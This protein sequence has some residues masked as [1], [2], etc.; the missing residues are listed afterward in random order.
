MAATARDHIAWLETLG[1]ADVPSVGG[2][3][4]SLGEMIRHLAS[5]GVRVPGGFATTARPTASY[6]AANAIAARI[7]ALLAASSAARPACSTPARR[8]RR[9]LLEA[10]SRTP[11]PTRS[12]TP[13]A[14][15]SRRYG[16]GR[17]RTSR[18][19]RSATAE[20]L[21][22]ASFAGQQET[23]LNVR[24]DGDAAGRLPA[25]LR[26]AVHRPRDQLPR[27]QGLRP[28]R[29]GALGR[30]AED[31]A[32]RPRR[33]GRHVH[34]RHRDR[35]PRRGPHQRRLG[36]GR[37]RRAGRGRSRTSTRSSSRCSTTRGSCRSSRRRSAARSSSWSTPAAAA[38]APRTVDTTQRERRQL[39]AVR[40][41]DPAAGPLG[42]RRRGST[43]A[44][45]MD[46]EW[47]KDGESGE[48]FIVQA[49]PE[50]VQS[51]APERRCSD[52]A[53]ARRRGRPL[54]TRRRRRR[55]DRRPA[56][57][58]SSAHPPGHRAVPDGEILVTEMTDPD[59][60]PIMKRAAGDRHR[61]W[62]PHLPRRHRQPRAGRARHR[63][64][65]HAAR[66]CCTTGTAVTRLLRRGRRRARST[67]A[68]CRSRP[69]EVDLG[70]HPARRAPR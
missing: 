42:G 37:E 7:R 28:P 38:R 66:P 29:G 34:A 68:R 64:H 53:A 56:R 30:R 59:W 22:D 45:P 32:L 49:R 40:R 60:V 4:A 8:S 5:G 43:T 16:V 31:G 47:A 54:L 27:R 62:R 25:L 10:S 46:I 15:C 20:D 67:T 39:R 41:R 12:A 33:R 26:L 6:L 50:T 58:A 18:C 36:P 51:R 17:S 24:G 61:P 48:L 3:N 63:R 57:V 21:P 11:S 70:V 14:S 65:R 35:L 2:K 52:L 13:T 23:Y 69:T 19:A 55:G 9:L 44:R 1:N